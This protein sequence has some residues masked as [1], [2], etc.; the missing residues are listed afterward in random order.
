MKLSGL[1]PDG[2]SLACGERDA[3]LHDA[4]QIGAFL[5]EMSEVSAPIGSVMST[6]ACRASAAPAPT[7]SKLRGRMPKVT[8]SPAQDRRRRR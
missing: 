3:A 2:N 6:L 1:A 4:A 7:N 5:D 8:L